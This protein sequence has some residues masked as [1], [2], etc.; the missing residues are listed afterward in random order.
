[1]VFL[2]FIITAVLPIFTKS[3]RAQSF[4]FYKWAAAG[5]KLAAACI[6]IQGNEKN[7]GCL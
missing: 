5:H 6:D 3:I 7:E 1:M 2:G 4:L